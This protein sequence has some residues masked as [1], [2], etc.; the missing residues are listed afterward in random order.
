MKFRLSRKKQ[1]TQSG[2]QYLGHESFILA[3][4]Y[5]PPNDED[6]IKDFFN[7]LENVR[8]YAHGNNLTGVIFVGDL[9]TKGHLWG[10]T[11]CNNSGEIVE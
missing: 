5:I 4:A 10:D 2:V 6:S 1:L 9:N 3:T 7:S 11:R 8:A